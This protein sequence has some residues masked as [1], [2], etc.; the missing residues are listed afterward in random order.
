MK[1]KIL[2]TIIL[3]TILLNCFSTIIMA[4]NNNVANNKTTNETNQVD[5]TTKNQ[6]TTSQNKIE[7]NVENKATNTTE[8]KSENTLSL[9]LSSILASSNKFFINLSSL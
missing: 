9:P 1:R 2:V 8:E 3:F 4:A 7:N 5:N 6:N